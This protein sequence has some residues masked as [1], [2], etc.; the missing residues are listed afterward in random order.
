MWGLFTALGRTK[1]TFKDLP[2]EARLLL[3]HDR[4]SLHWSISV[5]DLEG[6]RG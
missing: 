4:P 3:Y 5:S 2:K 1:R 6:W